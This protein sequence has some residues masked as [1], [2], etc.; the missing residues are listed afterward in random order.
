MKRFN[1][2]DIIT[3]LNKENA[4]IGNSYYFA[5]TLENL[6]T[7]VDEDSSAVLFHIDENDISAPFVCFEDE[8]GFGEEEKT[9]AYACILPV[10]SVK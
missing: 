1:S 3:W 4:K 6:Q 7:T 10:E 8:T 9:F 5:D 2:K